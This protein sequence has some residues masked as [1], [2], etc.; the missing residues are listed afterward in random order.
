MTIA[1][2]AAVN[3]IAAI[4]EELGFRLP[5]LVRTL[6]QDTDLNPTLLVGDGLTG[7]DGCFIRCISQ[8]WTA[9]NV[10]GSAADIFAPHVLQVVFEA[11][12]VAGVG[13]D[14]VLLATIVQVV[15]MLAKKGC[16]VEVYQETT[17]S[18]ISVADFVA[19]KLKATIDADLSGIIGNI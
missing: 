12:T 15:A 3:I 7:S 9:K 18:G 4:N 16:R 2:Q 14:F 10:F 8:V 19:S 13:A 17:G 11:N 1:T 5:L 6:G